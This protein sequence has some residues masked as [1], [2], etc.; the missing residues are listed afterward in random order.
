M[1]IQ[2]LN[3]LRSECGK[4]KWNEVLSQAEK[5][6]KKLREH[7]AGLAMQGICNNPDAFQCYTPKEISR[8]AIEQA[9]SLIEQL[10]RSRNV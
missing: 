9:D 3:K 4:E 2:R 8:M 6:K 10:T 1:S 5:D 7:Y